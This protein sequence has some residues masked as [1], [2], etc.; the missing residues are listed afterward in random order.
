MCKSL[1]MSEFRIIYMHRLHIWLPLLHN[2]W[3]GT[4]EFV[5]V[6]LN[7]LSLYTSLCS[8]LCFGFRCLLS[9]VRI[10]HFL[11]WLYSFCSFII[12]FI[13]NVFV[14]SFL[15]WLTLWHL[16]LINTSILE[17]ELQ[18]KYVWTET[19]IIQKEGNM[20]GSGTIHLNKNHRINVK[21]YCGVELMRN[22]CYSHWKSWRTLKRRS[23]F[24]Y[25]ERDSELGVG[26]KL[27]LYWRKRDCILPPWT[28][29]AL[30]LI[31]QIR[32]I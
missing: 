27:L 20:I 24:W 7:G 21:S 5:D 3:L 31:W 22:I 10:H 8:L 26:T 9:F 19:E 17:I 12:H 13:A 28:S 14:V 23:L 1:L 15:P 18:V 16:F 30:A 4:R 32:T 11:D 2:M 6:E 25:M 29:Q